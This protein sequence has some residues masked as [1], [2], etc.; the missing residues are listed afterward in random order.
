MYR[1]A[2]QAALLCRSIKLRPGPCHRLPG[3]F[4]RICK[5]A[6]PGTTWRPTVR[7]CR[8]RDGYCAALPGSNTQISLILVAVSR[9]PSPS[10]LLPRFSHMSSMPASAEL[11]QASASSGRNATSLVA[12][13]DIYLRIVEHAYLG[14]FRERSTGV[15]YVLPLLVRLFGYH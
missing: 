10:Q 8:T 13:F 7:A 9:S 11:H 5:R 3:T 4:V 12:Q 1:G 14:F 15:S 6:E 2:S